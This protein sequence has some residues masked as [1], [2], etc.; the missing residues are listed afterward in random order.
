LERVAIEL[1]F[2]EKSAEAPYRVLPDYTI[3]F[4]R[5]GGVSTILAG[6]IGAL[7]VA[8]LATLLVRLLRRQARA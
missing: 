7:V 3:P 4:L 2:L 8:V 6:A 5:P 1:G